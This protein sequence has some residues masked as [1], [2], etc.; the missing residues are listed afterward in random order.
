MLYP[1]Q[2]AFRETLQVDPIWKFRPDPHGEGE[3]GKWYN[4]FDSDIEIAVPG[5]WNEQLEEIG[6]LHYV[7]LTWYASKVFLPQ[8]FA[9]KRVWLR[10]GSADF[11]SKMWVNGSFVGEGKFGFLPNDIE[12]TDFVKLNEENLVVIAVSNELND[13]S[14]PQGI[15]AAHYTNENRIREETNPP[16]RFDFSPFGGIHRPVIVYSTPKTYLNGLRVDTRIL[17]LSTGKVLIYPGIAGQW[18]SLSAELSD[19]EGRIVSKLGPL[20]ESVTHELI[21]SNCQFWSNEDPYLYTLKV[22]VHFNRK[23][24]DE[25]T[26][27][28]GV[29]EIK[30]EGDRLLL[31]GREVFLRGFGK[32]ED[33]AVAGRGLFLPL[34]IK[35]F[36]M[37]K[38]INCNS[39]RTSHY[40][41]AEEVLSYADEKGFLVIAEA[42]AVSLDLRHTT[43]RTLENHKEFI[44]R[45]VERDYNHPSIVIWAIGNEPNIVGDKGYYDGK[46]RKYWKD[47]FDFTRSLDDSRPITVPNCSQ[48]GTDDPV[49]EFSDI[50]SINRYY[51]WYEYPGNFELAMERLDR[52]MEELH[53]RY[54]KPVLITEFGADSLPGSHSSSLQMFTE[55]YQARLIEEYISHIES[56]SYTIGEIVWNFAD[57]RTPQHFRRVVLNLKGVFTRDREPKL[58]AFKLRQLWSRGSKIRGMRDRHKS[59]GSVTI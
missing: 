24:V 18:D 29:R 44:Q 46:G 59:L 19:R 30:V 28:I 37:M 42:P 16:T 56:K 38:W 26:L 55:E 51:G 27:K 35:D 50:L 39:F 10:V 14:I 11:T 9:D 1:I 4:G 41:Y 25:Y 49:F 54:K 22:F 23:T 7:G 57:F 58:S 45:M 17:D 47:V 21:V 2:N 6:L 20:K 5:S 31:N 43:Q 34:V 3:S 33:F 53:S 12:I 48:A 40:P 36:Q 13:D 15:T 8:H 52:E 32:H